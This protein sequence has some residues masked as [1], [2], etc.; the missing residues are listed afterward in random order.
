MPSRRFLKL[1]TNWR[2]HEP[3]TP[4]VYPYW[5]DVSV[6]GDRPMVMFAEGSGHA[7]SGGYF[8]IEQAV[9]GLWSAHIDRAGGAWLRPYLERLAAGGAVSEQELVAEYVRRHRREPEAYHASPP[10][11]R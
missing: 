3:G 11:T 8:T 10:R 9:A 6:D 5:V 1:A 7:S 2:P 4:Y